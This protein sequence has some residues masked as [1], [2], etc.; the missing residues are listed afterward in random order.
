VDDDWRGWTIQTTAEGELFYYHEETQTSQWRTP[1]ELLCFLGH[2]IEA[3]DESGNTY[4]ANDMLNMSCWTD[5]RCTANIFQAAYEGDMF[6]MQL[7]I[8]GGGNL[9]VVDSS[10]ISALHFA[11]AS[12]TEGMAAFLLENGASPD[13]QDVSAGR[14]LHWACRYSHS[15][16]VRLLLER[17]AHPDRQDTNGDS[18]LH[19]AA[20][21]DCV[22]AV[23]YLINARASPKQ[24]TWNQGVMRTPAEVAVAVGAH[25]AAGMLQEYEKRLAS[26]IGDCYGQ[27]FAPREPCFAKP[28]RNGKSSSPA[29]ERPKPVIT[30]PSR[31]TDTDLLSPV[32]IVVRVA[33]RA[34]EPV[35][36]GVQWVANRIIPIDD[37]RTKCWEL[38]RGCPTLESSRFS[39]FA[40][41]IPR[42]AL[43]NLVPEDNCFADPP[44][45]E[46]RGVAPANPFGDA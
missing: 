42:D 33:R 2:W 11:C 1:R 32:D 29:K 30:K 25:S 39:R 31:D 14:P 16:A 3:S 18:P 4:W 46:G 35:V 23:Q 45:F 38:G 7:Y 24:R 17:H 10:G 27:A 36:R 15:E 13:I 21:V 44:G 8:Y 12:S 26:H 28:S 6:F 43:R 9:D 40:A 5:P 34:S 19:L 41:S 37:T 20:G 22:G